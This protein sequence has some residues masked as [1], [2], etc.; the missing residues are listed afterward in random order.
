MAHDTS[1]LVLPRATKGQKEAGRWEDK[2]LAHTP[3][4]MMRF[5]TLVY[6][7]LANSTSLNLAS[8]GKVTFSSQSKSSYCCPAPIL[9]YCGACYSCFFGNDEFRS[10]PRIQPHCTGAVVED[11]Y[12]VGID[13]TRDQEFSPRQIQPLELPAM[14]DLFQECV[15]V[16]RLCQL[17]LLDGLDDTVLANVEECIGEGF[18]G[19]LVDG[20]HESA[21]D[22]ESHLTIRRISLP[23]NDAGVEMRN[24]GG[25]LGTVAG[26]GNGEGRPTQIANVGHRKCSWKRKFEFLFGGNSPVHPRISTADREEEP[27]GRVEFVWRRRMNLEKRHHSAPTQTSLG[28]SQP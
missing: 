17:D 18:V 26:L 4:S 10:D 14:A 23:R 25:R 6:A 5:T 27:Q 16:P 9:R 3:A 24:D 12:S 11:T 20:G 19:A 15:H 7:F 22:K 2:G 21:R 28:D 1:C 13:E 8:V